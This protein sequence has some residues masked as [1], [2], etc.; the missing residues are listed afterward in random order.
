MSRSQP[1]IGR[2]D[3]QSFLL[4]DQ[5]LISVL[6][7]AL[8]EMRH[9]KFGDR[10]GP[11]SENTEVIIEFDPERGNTVKD[12][13]RL[14]ANRKD[15]KVKFT[16]V[17]DSAKEMSLRSGLRVQLTNAFKG[18]EGVLIPD[19]DTAGWTLKKY[20]AERR[21]EQGFAEKD[22]MVLRE[23]QIQA[24]ALDEKLARSL[25]AFRDHLYHAAAGLKEFPV[26]VLGSHEDLGGA[27]SA[28]DLDEIFTA[29]LA[30]SKSA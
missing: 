10:P 1:R 7:S 16:L 6:D 27:H 18:R 23:P 20:L 2:L 13:A 28:L 4:F 26:I 24:A 9:S 29:Y 30:V 19:F 8:R 17:V 14:I 21:K 25:K 11:F 3:E 22:V 12:L 5:E 15:R